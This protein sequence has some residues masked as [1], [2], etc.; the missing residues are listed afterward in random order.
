M[1]GGTLQF[2]LLRFV[3]GSIERQKP[4][5]KVMHLPNENEELAL[6]EWCF[7][8]QNVSFCMTLQILKD[9]KTKI[10]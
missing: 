5:R 1:Q 4:S 9:T 2:F 7:I 8:M 6:Y 10:D 3:I